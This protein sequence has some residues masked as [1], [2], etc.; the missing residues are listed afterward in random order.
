[1]TKKKS[2]LAGMIGIQDLGNI[3]LLNKL[4][5]EARQRNR[6]VRLREP[7]SDQ[8]RRAVKECGMDAY[9]ISKLTGVP[10]GVVTRFALQGAGLSLPNV[11]RLCEGLGL[12]LVQGTG[13]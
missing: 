8:L 10:Q 2:K 13:N 11:D 12:R 4:A 5:A 6:A 3:E 7:L 1:M 9:E